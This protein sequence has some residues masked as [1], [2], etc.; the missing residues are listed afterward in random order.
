IN[1]DISSHMATISADTKS[2]L[3]EFFAQKEEE[4]KTKNTSSTSDA[5]VEKEQETT[6]VEE[7]TKNKNVIT[8]SG[9]LTVDELA[10]ELNKDVTEIIKK[11]MSLGVMATINQDLD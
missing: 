1:I 9:A 5:K 8:Y 10:T 6:E 3:D 7:E 4:T 11:L 2:K